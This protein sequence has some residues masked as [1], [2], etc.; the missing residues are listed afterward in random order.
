MLAVDA[1]EALPA[2]LMRRPLRAF[3]Y[4]LSCLLLEFRG[5]CFVVGCV[6]G[7]LLSYIPAYQLGAAVWLI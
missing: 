5:G 6:R 4:V 7:S 2:H 3:E 1:G